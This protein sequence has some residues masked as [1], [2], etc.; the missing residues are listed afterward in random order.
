[1]QQRKTFYQGS[2]V[3]K[4]FHC[5][6]DHLHRRP[7]DVNIIIIIIIIALQWEHLMTIEIFTNCIPTA[8]SIIFKKYLKNVLRLIFTLMLLDLSFKH[9]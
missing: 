5:R 2:T 8:L 1:M 9:F 4:C 7:V 6:V 3:L